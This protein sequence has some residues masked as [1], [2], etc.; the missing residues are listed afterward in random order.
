MIATNKRY[1]YLRV[2]V[3]RIDVHLAEENLINTAHA[4][5]AR[6]TYGPRPYISYGP[7]RQPFASPHKDEI[8]PY[9]Q[10]KSWRPK[11]D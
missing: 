1:L 2:M 5:H 11:T 3:I 9:T 7:Y 8:Y 6:F 4:F 10:K